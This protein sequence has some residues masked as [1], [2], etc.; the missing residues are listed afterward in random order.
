MIKDIH[1]FLTEALAH[2]PEELYKNVEFLNFVRDIN[3][4][5]AYA[6]AVNLHCKESDVVVD[7]IQNRKMATETNMLI[8]VTVADIND[9]Q[10]R[11]IVA[12]HLNN[13]L[14]IIRSRYPDVLSNQ[15]Y[16]KKVSYSN[17][18][19]VTELVYEKDGVKIK[20]N[21]VVKNVNAG[22]SLSNVRNSDITEIMPVLLFSIFNYSVE[23]VPDNPDESLI[24]KLTVKLKSLKKEHSDLI[25]ANYHNDRYYSLF[26]NV[27]SD[28]LAMSKIRAGIKLYKFLIAHFGHEL[29]RISIVANE[30]GYDTIADIGCTLR[31]D[32]VIPVSVKS[33]NSMSDAIKLKSVA[34]HRLIYNNI[35][36]NVK[37]TLPEEFS[38]TDV[39]NGV[40]AAQ[41]LLMRLS[42]NLTNGTRVRGSNETTADILG[43]CIVSKQ[44]DAMVIDTITS[45]VKIVYHEELS[46]TNVNG[47]TFTGCVF[48]GNVLQVTY[49]NLLFSIVVRFKN[50][51][52]T[53]DIYYNR[54]KSENAQKV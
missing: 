39:Q 8:Y 26:D 54:S 19:P 44:A 1:E 9:V 6:L 37:Y 51:Y 49:G 46:A 29:V 43:Y 32:K 47:T 17:S 5:I 40:E 33:Y 45:S 42:H 31:N 16:K 28:S 10:N 20:L 11:N 27:M 34:W 23:E 25:P 24:F 22:I 35:H 52:P 41:K 2:S 36:K 18:V 30:T 15:I 53:F 3:R 4:D 50:K 38:I 48:N 12:N 7:I 14:T 21:Y 13:T